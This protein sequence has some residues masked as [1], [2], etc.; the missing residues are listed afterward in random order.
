MYKK[1]VILS[2]MCLVLI[3]ILFIPILHTSTV[4]LRAVKFDA[5]GSEVSQINIPVE[6]TVSRS[7][8]VNQLKSVNIEQFDGVNGTTILVTDRTATGHQDYLS[9]TVASG[10]LTGDILTP[11][12]P[13]LDSLQS[14]AI[15]YILKVDA[16]CD[17][18]MIQVQNADNNEE[19]YYVASVSGEDTAQE[20]LDF[21]DF[22]VD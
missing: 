14:S 9:I 7:L 15:R 17:R 4:T 21:F 8:L 16:N 13:S 12:N 2:I 5:S 20:L 18:W 19:F 6:Y 22:N 11:E 10:N 1:L 3:G